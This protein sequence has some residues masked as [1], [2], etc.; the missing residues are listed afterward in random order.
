MLICPLAPP[1]EDVD[2]TQPDFGADTFC[3]S[4]QEQV[5][6]T[7]SF[8]FLS[9]FRF[10]TSRLFG[11]L[12]WSDLVLSFGNGNP[13]SHLA[14]QRIPFLCVSTCAGAFVSLLYRYL[15]YLTSTFTYTYT[16]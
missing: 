11:G 3:E 12:V 15:H 1:Q 13:P 10:H 6:A 16:C 2:E 8:P 14:T 5:Q 7:L 4:L 9:L